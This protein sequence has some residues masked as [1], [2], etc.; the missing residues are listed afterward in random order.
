[1]ILTITPNPSLDLLF[2]TDE[3]LRWDDANR[4]AQPRRRPG[5]QGINLTRAARALGGRSV[6]IALLGGRTGEA[7]A[8]DLEAE[9][10]A[11][12]PVTIDGE[13]RTFVAVRESRSGRNL[14]VNPRGP[15]CGHG[16]EQR[17]IDAVRTAI[18]ELRPTWVVSSG[19]IPPGLDTRLHARMGELARAAGARFVADCDGAAL[20]AA[21][22]AAVCDLLAPNRHEAH[23]LA[24]SDPADPITAARIARDLRTFAGVVAVKLGAE[25]AVAADAGGAWHARPPQVA[26]TSAVG[27]GDAFLAALLLRL[28]AGATTA[29]ALRTAVAAGAA[30]LR[31]DGDSLIDVAAMPALEAASHTERIPD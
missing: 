17:L 1:M 2:N 22:G 28:D 5:G 8:A 9:G 31:A 4:V 19:S 6:A 12:R 11:L 26:G 27:A 24:G 10:T 20:R 7:L 23:R 14:L 30:V 25:G 3:P 21:A 29:E 13:T 16:T 18:A 15:A